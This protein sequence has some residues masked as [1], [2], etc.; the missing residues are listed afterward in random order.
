MYS[1]NELADHFQRL[2]VAPGDAVMLHASVRAVGPVI[3]G[4]DQI[5][6]A[7]K[8]VLTPTGTLMMYAG[9]PEFYDDIGRGHLT[10]LQEQE[11]LEK[12]PASI[13]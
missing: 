1:R 8:D 9:C 13:L 2:A 6:L 11:I 5:H 4:P 12:H 3:G 10:S 7:L